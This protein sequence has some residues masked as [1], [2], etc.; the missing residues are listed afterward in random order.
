MPFCIYVYMHQDAFLYI[1]HSLAVY[2]SSFCGELLSVANNEIGSFGGA[3]GKKKS[4]KCDVFTLF[5]K[6]CAEKQRFYLR[7][8]YI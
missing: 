8:K 6:H 1:K 4:D 3:D 2:S 5:V 7:L